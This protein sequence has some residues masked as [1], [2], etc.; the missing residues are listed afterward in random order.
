MLVIVPKW[1]EGKNI[2][3]LIPNADLLQQWTEMIE[4]FYTVP[5]TIITNI[6]QWK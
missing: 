3:V 2:I 5:Y 4:T 1:H 6:E